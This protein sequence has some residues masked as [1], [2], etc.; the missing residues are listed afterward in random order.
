MTVT[1]KNTHERA[2]S[3]V[4]DN[5]LGKSYI[6]NQLLSMV[7]NIDDISMRCS[8]LEVLEHIDYKSNKLFIDLENLLISDSQDEI[9]KQAAIIIG[10]KF[11]EQGL[12][13]LVFSIIHEKKYDN[14]I[15]I[16]H[17]LEKLK[18]KDIHP[19]L[20][21]KLK[22]FGDL[23]I[24]QVKKYSSN[25]LIQIFIN[26]LTLSCLNRKFNNLK[27]K[28]ENGYIT[29]LDFSQVDNKILDWHYR[30]M[31]QDHTELHG[32]NHLMQIKIIIPFSLKWSIKND[33][34]MR[35]QV[36]LL[37][38]IATLRKN[39]IKESLIYQM[40]SFEDGSFNKAIKEVLDSKLNLSVPKLIDIFLNYLVISFL[41]N[42][43]LQIYFELKSGMVSILSIENTKLIKIPVFIEL[44]SSLESLRL[45]K[46]NIYEIPEFIGNL[47]KIKFLDLS[48]N[49]ISSMPESISKLTLLRNLNLNN[50]RIN[51]IPS[52]LKKENSPFIL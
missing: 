52:F 45:H 32:I 41:K 35:C 40:K 29:E 26:Q 2:F 22:V 27:Y 9:R 30:E 34:T 8:C 43:A 51:S 49:K 11:H 19:L 20:I 4:K 3:K 6:V 18:V 16:L 50:N 13:A 14:L 25:Q 1:S 10:K 47:K 12:D 17:I 15:T 28:Q 46:C 37:K 36:E 42:K 48:Y 44:L 24:E 31:I 38:T 5:H 21:K 33:F 7:E 23:D 39:S